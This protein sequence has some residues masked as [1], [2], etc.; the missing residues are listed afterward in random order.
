M[1]NEN[2]A[3]ATIETVLDVGPIEGANKI[4]VAKIR[5]WKCVVRK[6]QFK[7]GDKCVF[8]EVD[9]VLPVDD[10]FTFLKDSWNER[11]QGYRLKTRKLRGQI[12]QGLALPISEFPEI[13]YGVKDGTLP[14]GTDVT[15]LLEVKLY[16]SPDEGKPA[17]EPKKNDFPG[18]IPKTDEERVQNVNV[19]KFVETLAEVYSYDATAYLTSSQNI[20]MVDLLLDQGKH[21]VKGGPFSEDP[22]TP[23]LVTYVS[24][25]VDGTSFTVYIRDGVWGMCSRNRELVYQDGDT[26]HRYSRVVTENDLKNQMLR[27]AEQYDDMP[28]LKQAGFP[29]NLALQGEIVGPGIQKNVYGLH[30]PHFLIYSVFDIDTQTHVAVDTMI[31]VANHFGLETCPFRAVIPTPFVVHQLLKDRDEFQKAFGPQS[32]DDLVKAGMRSERSFFSALNDVAPEGEVYRPFW[33][34]PRDKKSQLT[35]KIVNAEY[36]LSSE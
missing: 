31:Q 3:L 23:G 36:L 27:Y 13:E 6:G 32:E 1:P 33:S 29:K 26:E 12:S 5:G 9:S 19:K 21:M 17:G 22:M 7:P 4:E 14:P 2:R 28:K 35:F 25:K 10:R 8:F 18:F 20:D 24:E 11:V 30:E 34:I 16:Q 15:D